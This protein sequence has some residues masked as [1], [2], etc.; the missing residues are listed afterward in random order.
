MKVVADRVVALGG[1]R[2]DHRRRLPSMVHGR[3][4]AAS[5]RITGTAATHNRK[6]NNPNEME[7]ELE[8]RDTDRDREDVRGIVIVPTYN[9]R[10][11]LPR[12]V[13]LILGQDP[14]L[15]V[16]IIDDASPDGTG[17]VAD[18]LAA[19]ESRVHVIHRQGK[20]GLGTA[21][22][23]GFRWALSRG[24][25]WFFQMDADFSHDPNHLP[26]FIEALADHDIVLGSRYLEGRVTVVNG[27]NG[28]R[29][30]ANL[31]NK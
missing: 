22:L 1:E 12:L 21:Y 9:E 20:L 26:R 19:A 4:T 14:R 18:E 25:D 31:T 2:V 10:S 28:P 30:L 17:K 11:N 27:A 3:R 8:T 23:D 16:L 29:V 7:I 5:R 15:E 13:P 6:L 24:Y